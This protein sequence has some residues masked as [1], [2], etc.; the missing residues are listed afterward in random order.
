MVLEARK[1]RNEVGAGSFDVQRGPSPGLQ[2]DACLTS[3]MVERTPA[4]SPVSSTNHIKTPSQTYYPP[5][6]SSR[7]YH[8][9]GEGFNIGIWGWG[10]GHSSMTSKRSMGLPSERPGFEA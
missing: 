8:M 3:Y 10:P 9:E 4:C 7:Y 2:R 1:S 5:K 6:S